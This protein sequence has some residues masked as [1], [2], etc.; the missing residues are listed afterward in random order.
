MKIDAIL[1]LLYP[2]RCP[3]CD[4]VL[5]QGAGLVCK[6]HKKLPYVTA[7]CCLKCGKEVETWEQEY[8]QDC[9]KYSKKF[10]KGFPVFNYIEPIKSSVLAIKYKNKREYCD[11]Y[12][13]EIVK[14]I[15][16]ILERRGLSGIV[17]VPMYKSKQRKRGFNQAQVLAKR[18]GDLTGI[19]VYHNLLQRFENT[20]PQK[21]LNPTERAN[22]IRRS[23]TAC[24]LPTGCRQVLLIDDI[25]TTGITIE[26]CTEL[27]LNAGVEQV[28]FATICIG[29]GRDI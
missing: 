24:N 28:Y 11:F 26:A 1:D 22:N 8:C 6:N 10:Q 4:A 19:P 20:T 15:K 14:K 3:V 16:P 27:L 12:G 7:P 13:E 9:Q 2:R 5:P 21:D 29:K 23:M 17:P 18:V 25:Y